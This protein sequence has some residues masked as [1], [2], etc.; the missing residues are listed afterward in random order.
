MG[1]GGLPG[2]APYQFLLTT[3]TLPDTNHKPVSLAQLTASSNVLVIFY[4]GYW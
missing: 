3:V 1:S 4:R 2:Y